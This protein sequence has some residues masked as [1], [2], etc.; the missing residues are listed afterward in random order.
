M[1]GL[2]YSK[3]TGDEVKRMQGLNTLMAKMVKSCASQSPFLKT[4]LEAV[5]I[6]HFGRCC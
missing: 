5:L 4:T 6:I 1:E 2:L 3:T